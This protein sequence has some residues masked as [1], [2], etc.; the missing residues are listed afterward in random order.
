M[1]YL[2]IWREW[3]G[4]ARDPVI[5][6]Q[7]GAAMFA[8][9]FALLPLILSVDLYIDDIERAMDGSR[10]WV[11]VGRPLADTLVEW[12]NFGSPATAVA[13]LYTL[14]AIAFLSSVGVAVARVHGIRSPFWTAIASLPLMAQ[15]YALQAMSYGFDALFMAAALACSITA[16]LLVHF[17]C[18]WSRVAAALV[19]QLFAFN[20]YQPGANGFLVMTGCLCIAS[21]LGLLNRPWQVL[22]LRLRLILSAVVY[23][24]GY[25]LYRLLFSLLFEHRLN[26]YASSAAELKPLDSALPM[27]LSTSVIEPLQQLL[28]DFGRWPLVLPCCLF[29]CTYALLVRQW[30]SWLM[31]LAVGV[32]L[33]LVLLLSPGGMLLLRESF[34]RHPRVLLYL[35]P[36]GT[37]LILQIVVMSRSIGRPFWRLG[38]VP[39]IWLMVVV[40]YAY[41]HGFAAQARFEQA[42][43]SRIVAAA[44]ALQSRDMEHPVRFLVVDGTMPRSPVLQ[45]TTRKFPLMDRLIPPLLDGNQTFSFSQLRL[46]GLDLEKRRPEELEGGWPAGCEPSLDAICSSEFSLQ[47]VT[48][49]TFVLQIA[50]ERSAL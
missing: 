4:L 2:M 23:A 6:R 9:F 49:D 13:P 46:H 43:L 48:D 10:G 39:L 32:G 40:S 17:R 26:R 29:I 21:V 5:R 42:R 50:P 22:S 47:R 45:N 12:L 28:A 18:A 37:C 36:L 27:A 19:L 7:W 20:L 44:S 41:G 34:V 11:R 30:R 31:A 3:V 14:V 38:M 24:G 1:A 8:G 25:G 35:G 16:A 15:P 33:F